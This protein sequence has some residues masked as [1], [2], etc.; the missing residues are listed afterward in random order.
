[1]KRVRHGK[2]NSLIERNVSLL[3]YSYSGMHLVL[4]Y[5]LISSCMKLLNMMSHTPIVGPT[6]RPRG[7]EGRGRDFFVA[8]KCNAMNKS[9][10]TMKTMG[11]RTHT[12]LHS[13]V[14]STEAPCHMLEFD[15]TI[16]M[17]QN[18]ILNSFKIKGCIIGKTDKGKHG[19]QVSQPVV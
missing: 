11:A 16:Q 18:H 7:G 19:S 14:A 12:P 5:C 1:M 3:G 15:S 17:Q 8:N 9:L 10:M 4:N 6:E 2:E 13:S